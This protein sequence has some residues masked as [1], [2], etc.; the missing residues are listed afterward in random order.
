MA[1]SFIHGTEVSVL[2]G[3]E[4]NANRTLCAMLTCNATSGSVS[5]VT[6]THAGIREPS[7]LLS[8]L[9]CSDGPVLLAVT[10]SV[11]QGPLAFIAVP[12]PTGRIMEW[13]LSSPL[14]F[15]AVTHAAPCSLNTP[16]RATASSDYNGAV[17]VACSDQAAFVGIST[18]GPLL[19]HFTYSHAKI[20]SPEQI[21]VTWFEANSSTAL[22][23]FLTVGWAKAAAAGPIDAIEV[24]VNGVAALRDASGSGGGIDVPLGFVQGTQPT[25]APRCNLPV[26]YVVGNSVRGGCAALPASTPTPLPP[27]PQ[28][29]ELAAAATTLP[30]PTWVL[31]MA[32]VSPKSASYVSVAAAAN[33]QFLVVA[34]TSDAL[35]CVDLLTGE[36][37]L[38]PSDTRLDLRPFLV[39]PNTLTCATY[40]NVSEVAFAG[41]DGNLTTMTMDISSSP[42]TTSTT[43]L[44]GSPCP[45]IIA[46]EILATTS[47][48]FTATQHV[49][50]CGSKSSVA[51]FQCKLDVR[52]TSLRAASDRRGINLRLDSRSP[53]VGT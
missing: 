3:V 38:G 48:G 22:P 36:S 49:A 1:P 16:L 4:C 23:M 39:L 50:V 30:S 42:S 43:Q 11:G 18:A 28:S 13:S 51:G 8:A 33:A 5:L 35:A 27:P 10:H 25:N 19:Q 6:I 32:A 2:A 34:A 21:K 41:T 15:E 26:A 14:A 29:P 24:A 20:E 47:S 44:L 17:M 53:A 12:Q 31:L 45:T 46:A 40:G 37:K 7:V 9:L 52:R